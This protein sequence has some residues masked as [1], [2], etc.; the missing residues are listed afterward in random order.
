MVRA[1][2]SK[3]RGNTSIII[4]C[5][6]VILSTFFSTVDLLVKQSNSLFRGCN[7]GCCNLFKQQRPQT[8]NTILLSI[9]NISRRINSSRSGG[10]TTTT[11]AIRVVAAVYCSQQPVPDHGRG[12]N[13]FRVK[14]SERNPGQQAQQR[15]HSGIQII[16]HHR[17][18]CI[19]Y[20]GNEDSIRCI[21]TNTLHEGACTASNNTTLCSSTRSSSIGSGEAGYFPS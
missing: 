9:R 5:C 1:N 3:L 19:E 21:G 14:S 10:A 7:P 2:S 18:C 8:R 15:G 13:H 11:T 17:R 6:C 4:A 20:T 12:R 16:A